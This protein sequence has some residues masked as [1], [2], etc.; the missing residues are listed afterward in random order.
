MSARSTTERASTGA[1]RA[2]GGIDASAAARSA[3]VG[4]AAFVASYL[5]AFVLWTVSSLPEP[6]S[7]EQAFE[8]AI[9]ESVRDSVPAWKAAGYVQFNAQFVDLTY[10][11]GFGDGALNLIALAE[12][13]P[14]AAAYVVPPLLLAGA[15]YVAASGTPTA[16]TAEAAVSG[17]LVAVGY[18]VLTV[19]LAVVVTHDAGGTTLSV[20]VPSALILAGVVSPVVFG[21]IGGVVADAT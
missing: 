14:L 1:G 18:A 19:L 11:T 9:V 7:F 20:P 4:A 2:P 5:A 16:K 6:D 13:S 17:A 15:G 3:G 12:G 10:E 21:A 8:Q